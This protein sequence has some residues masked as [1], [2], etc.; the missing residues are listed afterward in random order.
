M[1]NK[2]IEIAVLRSACERIF[3]FIER[4]LKISSIELEEDL[5]WAVPEDARYDMSEIPTVSHVG[6][7]FDDYDF[8]EPLLKDRDQAIPLMFEH[9]APLLAALANRLPNQK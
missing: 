8:V 9:I 1:A 5:Y 3:E 6:N 7:L 2:K 4:D